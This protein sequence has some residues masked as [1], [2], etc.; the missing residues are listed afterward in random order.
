MAISFRLLHETAGALLGAAAVFMVSYIGGG[1]YPAL[2]ILNFEDA[3]TFVDWNVIFLILGMMIFM[4]V[5]A[6]T[7]VFKWLAFQ[8][9]RAAK[10]NTWRLC[11]SRGD[12]RGHLRTTPISS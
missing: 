12:K 3:M 8:L 11:L 5:L 6:E 9:Y 2:R 7:N 1:F 4:A 10:G